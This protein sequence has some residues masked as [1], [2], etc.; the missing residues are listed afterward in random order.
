MADLFE[1]YEQEYC[2]LAS[3]VKRNTELLPRE[4]GEK[5]KDMVRGTQKEMDEAEQVLQQ[6]EMEARSAVGGM[7]RKLMD[8]LRRYKDDLGTMKDEFKQAKVALPDAS[9]MRGSLLGDAGAMEEGL[10]GSASMDQRKRLL[11][12]TD[13]AQRGTEKIRE[14]RRIAA[15]TEDIGASTMV[16][17]EAQRETIKRAHDHVEGTSANVGRSRRIL[18]TMAR[19]V[20]TNKIIMCLI[21]LVLIG[22]IAMIVYFEFIKKKK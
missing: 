6:M 4:S 14:A 13:R 21:I 9:L 5:K 7:R 10:G 19:R 18:T 2:T 11:A 1:T 20:V 17:L 3:S 15:E 22:A 12:S 8:R 16:E